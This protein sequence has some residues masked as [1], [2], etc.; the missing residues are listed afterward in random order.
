[1]IIIIPDEQKTLIA[2][3]DI[4]V[5]MIAFISDTLDS[6]IDTD[7]YR[8]KYLED[9][10]FI[11]NTLTKNER[12]LGKISITENDFVH[13]LKKIKNVKDNTIMLLENI[14]RY[15]YKQSGIFENFTDDLKAIAEFYKI[16]SQEIQKK[17]SRKQFLYQ[18]DTQIS[19]E[20]LRFL[21]LSEES[22]QD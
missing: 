4:L 9:V 10:F 11:N 2:D 3:L 15:K 19:K 1:M 22:R 16:S 21:F 6:D 13:I 5:R 12:N 8:N 20:E 7:L 17:L 14:L 18:P